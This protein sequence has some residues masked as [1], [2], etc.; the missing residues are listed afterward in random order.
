MKNGFLAVTHPLGPKREAMGIGTEKAQASGAVRSNALRLGVIIVSALVATSCS[1]PGATPPGRSAAPSAPGGYAVRGVREPLTADSRSPVAHDNEVM[2]LAAHAGHLFA[3]TDQW[4]YPGPSAYGQVLVKNSSNSPW[5]VFEQTQSIRVQALDSFPIPGDQGLGPGHSLLITQAIVNGRSEIQ[6]LLDRATSFTPGNSYVLPSAA[7]DIRSFGAHESGGVW[8]VYAGVN[9]T[10]ILRGTWSPARHT[11]IFSSAPELTAAPPGSLGLKTQKVTA[12]ASCA[13]AMYVTINTKLYRRNDGSLP[14]GAARWVLLYQ[15][16]PVG[17]FNSG[18]RGLSCVTHDG[19]PSLLLSTEGNGDIY[20]LGHLPQG[21]LDDSA[22]ASPGHGLT[23][24][25][26]TLEFTPIPA[27]RQMLAAQGTTVPASGQGSIN[28]V[29]AAYN[30][31]ETIKVGGV[32]RQFFGFEWGYQGG[33]PATRKCGPTSFGVGTLTFDAA[34]CFAVRTDQG[35]SPAYALH[36]LSGPDFTPSAKAAT[37]IRSG[38]AFVSIRTIK[39]SPF[40]DGRLYY[41][42]YDC[43]FSPADGTAWIA[44]STVSALHLGDGA[45]AVAS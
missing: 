21:Q 16:P 40:G 18:L 2:A 1:G 7:A 37:P 25:I 45:N 5:Q 6:W 19:S 12:F 29:I 36:C 43:N 30:N 23:G 24:L 34:A 35:A 13:G 38:Q 20:R 44:S 11:L 33:C 39:L 42:G 10:G 17:A 27:I 8:A 15:E 22:A 4:E 14:P 31:F 9:P 41:G 32:I 3:A 26:P 28:Y